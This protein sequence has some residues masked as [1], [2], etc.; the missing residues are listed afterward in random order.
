LSLLVA[1][2]Q[3]KN[4]HQQSK[5]FLQKIFK[6]LMIFFFSFIN[7]IETSGLFLYFRIRAIAKKKRK[8]INLFLQKYTI[9]PHFNFPGKTTILF[10]A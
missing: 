4:Q 5:K 1:K 2:K 8:F 7:V 3:G 10:L 9:L 6:K